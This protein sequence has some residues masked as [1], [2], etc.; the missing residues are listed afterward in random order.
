LHGQFSLIASSDLR[1]FISGGA[2]IPI[3]TLPAD[4]SVMVTVMPP[5]TIDSPSFLLKINIFDLL[6]KDKNKNIGFTLTTT[7]RRSVLLTPGYGATT[8]KAYVIDLV[9]GRKARQCV[10]G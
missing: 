9:S 8:D 3:E 5:I 4:R 2:S 1:I 7:S 6:C 10:N